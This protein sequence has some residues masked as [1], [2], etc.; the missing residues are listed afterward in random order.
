M[1]VAVCGLIGTLMLAAISA[2][3]AAAA[4]AAALVWAFQAFQ[5]RRQNCFVNTGGSPSVEAASPGLEPFVSIH[6]AIY[7]EPPLLVIKTLCSLA[8]L[9]YSQFEVVVIDNNTEDPNVWRPIEAYVARLGVKFKFMH[10]MGVQGAKAGALNIAL[11][12]SDSRTKYVAVVDADYLVSPDFLRRAIPYLT[13]DVRFVQFPQA[14]RQA[15]GAEFLSSEL[16][17]YFRTFSIAANRAD[18]SLLTGTLSVIDVQALRA[19]GGW[20]TGSITEDAALGLGLLRY[21]YRGRYID[22]VVGRGLLPMDLTRLR[23]QRRR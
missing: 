3:N 17:D 20:P 6:V 5:D 7:N 19:V 4:L 8:A 2:A 1:S 11:D 13:G 22:S 15:G 12:S 21:G 23:T 9:D 10:V 18:A 16:G 14:Y